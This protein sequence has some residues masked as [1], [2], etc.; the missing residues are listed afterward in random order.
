MFL[1]FSCIVSDWDLYSGINGIVLFWGGFGLN[2]IVLFFWEGLEGGG[3]LN[4]K[5]NE[6]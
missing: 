4:Y 6:D 5:I 2:W 1:E 3:L